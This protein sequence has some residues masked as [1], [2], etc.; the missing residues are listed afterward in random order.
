MVQF[1]GCKNSVTKSR[2]N[3]A[4]K[5]IRNTAKLI[6]DKKFKGHIE[7]A[8]KKY[9][10]LSIYKKEDTKLILKVFQNITNVAAQSWKTNYSCHQ[11][12]TGLW[13]MANQLAIVPPVSSTVHLCPKF[14]NKLNKEKQIGTIIHE[15]F[16]RWGK[17]EINYL[18]EDYCYESKELDPEELIQNADQYMLFIYY[19]GTN[20]TILKCF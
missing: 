2:H 3:D 19:V 20:A 6:N 4:V 11:K 8:L 15:W 1:E 13:C 18:P 16:H 14:Y 5:M 12:S 17:S 7:Q 9:F 10:R